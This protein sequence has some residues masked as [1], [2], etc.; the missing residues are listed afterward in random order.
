MI[1]IKN[2]PIRMRCLHALVKETTTCDSR[3]SAASSTITETKS[4]YTLIKNCYIRVYISFKMKE[5]SG[6]VS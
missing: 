6:H 5:I 1:N 3:T 2:S 4:K